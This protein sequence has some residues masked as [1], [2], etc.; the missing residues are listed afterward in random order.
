[1]ID[2]HDIPKLFKEWLERDGLY[3]TL[4]EYSHAIIALPTNFD[5]QEGIN[6]LARE[7]EV[8]W[9]PNQFEWPDD[10]WIIGEDGAGNLYFISK[11]SQKQEVFFYNHETLEKEEFEPSIERYYQYCK[12]IEIESRK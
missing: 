7:S 9:F 12:D 10:Y 6:V 4:H 8:E 2:I 3:G 11:T 5:D 1:M